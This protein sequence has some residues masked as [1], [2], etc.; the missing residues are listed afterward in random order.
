[1]QI[2]VCKRWHLLH[3]SS[4]KAVQPKLTTGAANTGALVQKA[5]RIMKLIAF[6]ILATCLQVNATDG[7]GQKVTLSEREVHI[8]KIFTEIKKQTGFNFLYTS[9]ILANTHRVTV[10]VTNALMTEVLDMVVAGQGLEY[11][12]KGDDKLIIIK[13]KQYIKAIAGIQ[14]LKSGPIDVS[15]SV[16]DNEGRPLPGANVKVRGSNVGVVTDKDGRFYLKDIPENSVLE[17][18]YVGHDI[19]TFTVRSSGI[20]NIALEQKLSMMDETVVIGYG[21][22]TNRL[23]TGN[24]GVVK[25]E[26]IAKQPVN[27]PLLALQG[28][29]PGLFI[30]QANGLPGSGVQVTIQG[31]NS[32][33]RGSDPFY[34]IDGVPYTSLLLANYGSVLGNSAAHGS[35]QTT[36][37]NPLSFLNPADIES[38]SILKDADATAI[39]GSRGANGVILITTKKGKSGQTRIDINMQTGWG[40]VARKLDLLDTHQYQEMR[41]EAKRNDNAAITDAD[42]DINGFWDTTR[43]TDWQKELIGNA[44]HYTDVNGTVSGGNINTQVLVG[45]GYHRET[46]VF[47]GDLSDQKGSVHFSINNVSTNQKFRLLLTGS[48]LEDNNRIIS[49]DLTED[50]IKLAP[51]A[52]NI[53]TEDGLLNWMPNA[54]GVSSWTN[55]LAYLNNRYKNKTKNLVGNAVVSYKIIPDLEIKSSFGYTNL[56]ANEIVTYPLVSSAP[57]DRITTIRSALYSNNNIS[58]W[59]IEPQVS[60][61]TKFG[62]NQLEVLIGTTIQQ[63]IS[64][65]LRLRGETYNSDVV[66]DDVRSAAKVVIDG[67][68]N[69]VYKYNALF[70][71][72]TYNLIDKYIINLT[73]RRDG[74]SRFG[75]GNQFHNFGAA[76]I[77]WIFSKERFIQNELPF[78]SFGKLTASYGSTGNDQIGDYQFMSLYSSSSDGV[79]YQGVNGMLAGGLPNALLQWEET[80][81]LNLG[82]NV[83]LFKERVILAAN[84]FQNRS[85]NQLLNYNL[86]IQTGFGSIFRNLPATV[87]N[88]GWEFTLSTSNINTKDFSWS[89]DFNLTVPKNQL[90]KFNNIENSGYNNTYFVGKSITLTKVNSWAGVNPST[91]TYQ[92]LD[93]EG[94]LT[95]SPNSSKDR[96]VL[97]NNSPILYGGIHNNIRYKRFEFDFSFQLV[98]R[99]GPNYYFGNAAGAYMNYNQPVSVLQRWRKPGDISSIQRYNSNFGLYSPSSEAS[100]S[101]A[102]YGDASFARLKNISLS[103]MIPGSW[104]KRAGLTHGRLYMQGQNLLTITNYIGLDPETLNSVSLPPLKVITVGLQ[105]GF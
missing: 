23:K 41:R 12:V 92:F 8:E 26:D 47:P 28:R 46:T 79:P 58:S 103:W 89:C 91:G 34:V 49:R 36:S 16:T 68:V 18:S 55:P 105:V 20:V 19:K 53:Y 64:N 77:G 57:E 100:I 94:K 14:E 22:T 15:G 88:S 27:N 39:Y 6:L 33:N 86:P 80:K 7:F 31:K 21:T 85:S 93:N 50:A 1:M 38:I 10:D 90:L 63:N 72:L 5:L 32:L 54:S 76:G 17:I 24:V 56:Q 45:V 42:Y 84:Y 78:I 37:G 61:K 99:K 70:S 71:R 2:I 75:P 40:K 30:T 9:N 35:A 51:N 60:Y 87:Q 97:I 13:Q 65:G 69:S 25:A 101:D 102:A 59:I 43:Y 44:S 104:Y 29:V 74:S 73:L 4:S 62:K 66:L 67:T 83:G 98:N 3:S 52:P 11:R 81:K 48:Y 82:L 96:T 95:S